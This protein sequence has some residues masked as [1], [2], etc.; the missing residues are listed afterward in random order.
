VVAVTAAAVTAKQ[1][2]LTAVLHK[3]AKPSASPLF[4]SLYQTSKTSAGHN[5]HRGRIL[6]AP[7]TEVPLVR[8]LALSLL[9]LTLPLARC[10]RAQTV[11]AFPSQ[12]DTLHV[13]TEAVVLEVVVTNASGK[14]VAFLPQQ[15]FQLFEDGVPQPILS[16]EEHD[17]SPPALAL[18]GVEATPVVTARPLAAANVL[19]LD[20]LNTL[21]EDQNQVR[22]AVITFLKRSAPG[23]PTAIFLLD[24][25]LRLIHAFTA[26]PA[27]LLAAIQNKKTGFFSHPTSM[28]RTTQNDAFQADFTETLGGMIS[29]QEGPDKVMLRN[30][31]IAGIEHAQQDRDN[32]QTILRFDTTILALQALAQSLAATPGRKNLVWFAGSF[33]QGFFS[34]RNTN[35][36]IIVD[37]LQTPPR[38]IFPDHTTTASV[39][40]SQSLAIA[41]TQQDQQLKRTTDLLAQAHVAIYPAAARG[42][43]TQDFDQPDLN[44]HPNPGPAHDADYS[45]Y[46]NLAAMDSL[47]TQTGGTV[48]QG[49]NDL[50][51][52]VATAL[53]TASHF[54]T[55]SY[56]PSHKN[57]DGKFRRIDLKL[58][59]HNL[60]AAYRHGYYA[61]PSL[62][63]NPNKEL[64]TANLH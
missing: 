16:F 29:P 40:A 2:V 4:F 6:K 44:V 15:D 45:H 20:S 56:T 27:A 53:Q 46:A 31:S 17:V 24:S 11:A 28:S 1:G 21:P 42:I 13:K 54:Y 23:I 62:D 22:S 50:A 47:A 33:P 3:A 5:S 58:A 63:S 43:E 18:R 41:A 26:D 49:N 37:Q 51:T 30:T 10:A 52:A 14:P 59:D 57:V 36:P 55:I 32:N 35:G 8:P 34:D 39:A 7:R 25:R 64:K 48:I 38:T 60:R 19:L 9:A 61:L 12:T